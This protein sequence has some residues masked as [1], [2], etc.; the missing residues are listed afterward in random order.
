MDYVIKPFARRHWKQV[1]EIYLEG[2]ETRNAT[3]ETE[4]PDWTKWDTSH[5]PFGRLVACARQE[6]VGWAALSPVFSRQC[7]RGVAELSVYVRRGCARQGIGE[8]LLRSAIEASEKGGI[9]TLQA[10]IFPENAASL[11]LVRKCGFREI[12]WRERPAQLGGVW[13]DTILLER[14]SKTVGV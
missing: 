11:A 2:V 7:Y 14:R 6:I 5:L 10:A 8:A 4:A 9:W 13:R 3:F 1:R 12:G